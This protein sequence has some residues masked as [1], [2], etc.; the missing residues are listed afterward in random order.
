MKEIKNLKQIIQE[1]D[2]QLEEM[3]KK[4]H[5]AEL[6]SQDKQNQQANQAKVA[7]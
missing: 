5:Q 7:T 2:V 1:K 3:N 4:I 6:Q